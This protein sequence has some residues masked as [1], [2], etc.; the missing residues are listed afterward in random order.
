MTVSARALE[1]GRLA[2]LDHAV[3][4]DEER[5]VGNDAALGVHGDEP[6]HMVLLGA[7]IGIIQTLCTS[8]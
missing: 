3:V 8:K 4:L 6:V 7:G 2:D 5:A 1:G